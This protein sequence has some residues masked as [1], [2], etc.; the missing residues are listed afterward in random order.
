[1]ITKT[2]QIN[3]ALQHL[4]H[5]DG[6]NGLQA[7]LAARRALRGI[8]AAD[9]ERE[10]LPPKIAEKL[11]KAIA[12]PDPDRLAASIERAAKNVPPPRLTFSDLE[13]ANKEVAAARVTYARAFES[14]R[15][16][17]DLTAEAGKG[18]PDPTRAVVARAELMAATE[19]RGQIIAEM[20]GRT[21]YHA[22]DATPDP[23]R[24]TSA[25]LERD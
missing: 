7:E 9:I 11:L 23:A 14:L 25:D 19:R 21:D 6:A 3:E 20:H 10:Q 1:M 18:D 24:A 22:R 8:K 17:I 13:T 15:A 4:D 12:S 5:V 16:E 2:D